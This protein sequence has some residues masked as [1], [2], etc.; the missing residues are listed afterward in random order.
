M[1]FT[2]GPR[3]ILAMNPRFECCRQRRESLSSAERIRGRFV[4][5]EGRRCDAEKPKPRRNDGLFLELVVPDPIVARDDDPPVCAGFLQPVNI[6]RPLRKELVMDTDFDTGGAERLGHFLPA[7]RS[8]DE[9][10]E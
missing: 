6:L 7:Q 3:E 10:Y 4:P 8:I 5:G 2:S 1:I 9:E